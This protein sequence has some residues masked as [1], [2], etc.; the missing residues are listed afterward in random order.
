[1]TA[2]RVLP[3]LALLSPLLLAADNPAPKGDLAKFQGKWTMVVAPEHDFTVAVE[4]KGKAVT[5]SG[6]LPNGDEFEIK[7]E[8]KLDDAAKPFKTVDWVN[9]TG[10]NGDEL[11]ANKGIYELVDADTIKIH[12]G[13]PGKERPGAFKDGDVEDSKVTFLKREKN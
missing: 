13:G 11:P 10:P 9:F 12:N 7:G 4:I 5:A 1:M 2:R 6:R 3:V 8:I